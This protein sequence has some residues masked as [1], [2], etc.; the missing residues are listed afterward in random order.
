MEYVVK[1]ETLI[2]YT[3]AMEIVLPTCGK[4]TTMKNHAK[5]CGWFDE[6]YFGSLREDVLARQ[7]QIKDKENVDTP[8]TPVSNILTPF[9]PLGLLSTAA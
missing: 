7:A 4:I 2:G 9:A 1:F 5:T 6:E 8:A 3:S